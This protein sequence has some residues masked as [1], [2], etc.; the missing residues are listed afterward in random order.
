VK[1]QMMAFAVPSNLSL[2]G[3][4]GSVAQVR[5]T[6]HHWEF[7]TG[8]TLAADALCPMGRIEQATDE[9]LAKIAEKA[10]ITDK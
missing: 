4:S 5:C 7:P 1:C 8:M 9:A 6:T 10:G 3:Y 2:V